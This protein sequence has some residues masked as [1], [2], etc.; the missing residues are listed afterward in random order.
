VIGG[1]HFFRFNNPI[2]VQ[3]CH[4]NKRSSRD[5]PKDFEFAKHELIERQN[6]RFVGAC[7][8]EWE[9]F[10]RINNNLYVA[11]FFSLRRFC[12]LFSLKTCCHLSFS[13]FFDRNDLSFFGHFKENFKSMPEKTDLLR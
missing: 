12:P 7:G 4:G 1:D 11:V 13:G 9:M 2:E 3:R 6:A 10:G 5:G 8:A